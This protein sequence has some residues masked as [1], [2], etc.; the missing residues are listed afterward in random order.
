[1]GVTI[2]LDG[3]FT[4][5]SEIHQQECLNVIQAIRACFRNE[6]GL[7]EDLRGMNASKSASLFYFMVDSVN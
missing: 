5:M 6:L 4:C 2:G 3:L 7:M 1:M